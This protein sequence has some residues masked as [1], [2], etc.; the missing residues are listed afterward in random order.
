[1]KS[2]LKISFV[3]FAKLIFIVNL[4]SGI[5]IFGIEERNKN[6]I[7]IDYLERI[8][9]ND[10]ILGPGDKLKI[11]VSRDYPE[12]DSNDLIDGEGT[13][14]L[15]KIHRVFVRGL[16]IKELNEVLNKRYLEFIKYPN[17][18]VR[19]T[20]YRPVKIYVDGEVESPGLQTLKGSLSLNDDGISDTYFPTVFDAIR[21]AGGISQ[22]SDLSKIE[23]IR[24]NS[25]SE[26][27][28]KKRTNLN[29]SNVL[30]KGDTSQNI[31]I[32][33]GDFIKISKTNDISLTQLSKA[34][35]SNL[36]PKFINV[37]VSGRVKN[38]G[39]IKLTKSST[40]NDAIDMAGGS[41]V[42]KGK[43]RFVRFLNDGQIDTRKFKYS[44]RNKR[45]SYEN[46][47]LKESDLIIIDDSI[48]TS[49]N[50]V[51]SDVTSPFVGIFST[52]S[53]IQALG[54]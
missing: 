6:A 51:V 33:D 17:L 44:K 10:Y 34:I 4:L 41:K 5:P 8:P 18:E 20:S 42:L 53:F 11:I 9:E 19:V 27:G 32:Y 35:Q 40:L 24:D 37:F 31:R 29:F 1:M 43:T 50:E 2:A 39:P 16:T 22:F 36:N 25:I 54:D 15:P 12:L 47:F 28:G 14:Y 3:F 23:L 26:G 30:T 13:I 45:G 38:P 52:Y 21:A 46:P 48:L 49:A 7:T